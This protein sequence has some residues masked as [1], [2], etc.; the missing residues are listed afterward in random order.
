MAITQEAVDAVNKRAEFRCEICGKYPSKP[1]LHHTF[2]GRRR[3]DQQ[4]DVEENLSLLCQRC[5]QSVGGHERKR[6]FWKK[7][8]GEYGA[9]HMLQWWETVNIKAKERFW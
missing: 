8:V 7:R 5:H 3:G 2:W 9:D 6:W 1:E 4:R